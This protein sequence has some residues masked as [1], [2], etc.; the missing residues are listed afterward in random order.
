MTIG[1]ENMERK[2]SKRIIL[3]YICEDVLVNEIVMKFSKYVKSTHLSHIWEF[4]LCKLLEK[5]GIH[6]DDSIQFNMIRNK[7]VYEFNVC[8]N[9]KPIEVEISI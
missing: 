3:V 9:K 6:F 7:S 2:I 1:K 5:I 8:L 4:V